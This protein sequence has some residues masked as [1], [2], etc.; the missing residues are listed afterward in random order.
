[1]VKHS[2]FNKLRIV[3]DVNASSENLQGVKE[4]LAIDLERKYGDTRVVSVTETPLEQTSMEFW[5]RKRL[6]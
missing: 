6:E 4:A 1:M 3:I 2:G 5:K